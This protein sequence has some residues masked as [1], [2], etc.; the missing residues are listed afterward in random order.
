M[1]EEQYSISYYRRSFS[2]T[3]YRYTK[4][5]RNPW[6]A[7]GY[8]GRYNGNGTKAIYFGISPESVWAE[9]K[10]HV[11]DANRD[12]YNLW[13]YP[14]EEMYF[15]DV[16]LFENREQ[17]LQG[18]AS[19]GYYPTQRLSEEFHGTNTAGFRFP[20]YPAYVTNKYGT[21]FCV[22]PEIFPLQS[23]NFRIAT[24]KNYE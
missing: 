24:T 14:V 10:H 13:E 3:L 16:G 6:D 20:S 12:D 23:S 9:I 4:T 1:T 17:Y 19:G 2:G 22:Y 7:S 15:A 18:S 8:A 5:Q 11:P 21:S